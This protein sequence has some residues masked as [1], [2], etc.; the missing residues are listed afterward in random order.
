MK[1]SHKI[2][3]TAIFAL[4][5]FVLGAIAGAVVWTLLRVMSLAIDL[6]WTQIP[7]MIGHRTI[8]T[9]AVCVAGGVV[10][11][12]FQKRNGILPDTLEEVMAKLEKDGGYPYDRM[13]TIAV[14]ALLPLIFGGCLGPEAGLT[15]IIVALCCWI[16]DKL[17]YKRAEA[18][19]L[20][21]AG[22][23][24]TL[25]VVFGAP[26]FGFVNNFEHSHD[27]N[28]RFFSPR[29]FSVA[30]TVVYAFGIVGGFSAMVGLGSL[31]KGEGGLPRFTMERVPCIG[32]WKYFLVFV[33]AGLL[34]GSIYFGFAKLAGKAASYFA[35]KRVLSCVIGGLCLGCL[36]VWNSRAMFSGEQQMTVLSNEWAQMGTML[37]VLT[38]VGKL[39]ALNICLG[40]GWRGGNIFPVIYCGAAAGYAAVSLTGVLPV[41]GVAAACAALCGYIMRKP[42]T[43]VAVLFLCFPIRLV[44]PLVVAAY[45]GS[46]VP[47]P[48][49]LSG[50]KQ[51][52]E[53]AQ[54]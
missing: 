34:C 45:I 29:E 46:I 2:K 15:G 5:A 38:T 27:E 54:K 28:K 18:Q 53:N 47:V 41:F 42:L 22:M 10:I 9:I 3:N 14:A 49:F 52:M 11:G 51:N 19:E 23:A 37:L 30:K 43:V 7:Q 25:G 31:F 32:D 44:V 50:R 4:Y 26:L 16:G 24:A 8:Y 12:L 35:E 13:M 1:A 40:F 6:V 21:E 20:A 33:A 17:K 39:L 36:G 48:A